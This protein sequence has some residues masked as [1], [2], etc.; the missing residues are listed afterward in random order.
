MLG[1]AQKHSE[2]V[3]V[4]YHPVVEQFVTY[5]ALDPAA[6]VLFT[7]LFAGVASATMRRAALGVAAM[8]F[9]TPFA[10]YH[11]LG[12]TTIT[13]P[14]V[15]ILAVAL[16]LLPSWRL[17][18][19]RLRDARVMLCAFAAILVAIAL[20]AL[21]A[22]DRGAVVT[23]FLKWVEYALFFCVAYTG[24]S[25]DP[26]NAW[27]RRAVFASIAIVCVT[28]LA[29]EL[30]GAPW[31]IVFGRGVA[32]RIA[33]VLEGPNQLAAYLEVA[34]AVVLAWRVRMP[35]LASTVLAVLIGLTLLLTF[36]R[37]GTIGSA[38]VLIVVAWFER[39]EVIRAAAPFVGAAVAGAIIDAAW[40]Q[41]ARTLPAL[42]NPS[43]TFGGAGGVGQRPELWRAAWF[44]FIRHPLFGVGAS[45]YEIRL[46]EAG[47]YGVRTHANSLYLQALAEGGIVLFAA[48]IFFIVA[49]LA[50]L[51]PVVKRSAW[52]LAAFAATVALAIH[53]LADYLI[54][55]PKVAE[56]W[57]VLI[58][59]GLAARTFSSVACD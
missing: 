42:R 17:A 48:T 21:G 8:A 56:P 34:V 45:N 4:Q 39:R 32:P 10:F 36:S 7:A 2:P 59:V 28:A 43:S 27:I 29:Q 25:I 9:V 1:F 31:D 33:G 37:G 11:T 47:V 55:Y 15:T 22:E 14:K 57:I 38:I 3:I 58:A 24:F 19:Q 52:A 13:F 44:F 23:E 51:R 16:G 50:E 40:A 18:L 5:P 6:L 30:I 53:Q 26:Q 46:S 41:A 20:S 12:V 54:F 49:T 35:S